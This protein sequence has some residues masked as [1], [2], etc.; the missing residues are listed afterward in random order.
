MFAPGLV[1]LA[2]LAA[3]D[4]SQQPRIEIW[5]EPVAVLG[6][7]AVSIGDL[8]PKMMLPIGFEYTLTGPLALHIEVTALFAD[9]VADFRH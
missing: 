4:P 2:A 3:A 5:S 8:A 7:A 6:S 9:S 1:C